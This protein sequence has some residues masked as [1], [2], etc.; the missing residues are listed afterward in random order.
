MIRRRRHGFPAKMG[1]SLATILDGL[2]D[3]GECR[4]LSA[5]LLDIREYAKMPRGIKPEKWPDPD[6]YEPC[7]AA[8][9]DF[10]KAADATIKSLEYDEISTA[11]AAGLGVKLAGLGARASRAYEAVK[12]RRGALDFDDLLIRTRALLRDDASPV[13]EELTRRYS[14]ILIDEFQD[15]DP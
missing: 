9:E 7:K 2:R 3:L 12:R 15:T 13:R 10:R 1:E 5:T 14:L 8:F 6:L 11:A 4:D